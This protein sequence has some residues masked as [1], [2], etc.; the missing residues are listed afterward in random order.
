M[1][2]PN[3]RKP[4]IR[5][6]KLK[7]IIA[8]CLF[9]FLYAGWCVLTIGK[10]R[11]FRKHPQRSEAVGF[12]GG[13]LPHKILARALMFKRGTREYNQD[14][15]LW[16]NESKQ[17]SDWPW[18][19]WML[20]KRVA[21]AAPEDRAVLLQRYPLTP[22][23]DLIPFIT[24]ALNQGHYPLLPLLSRTNSEDAFRIY[25]E[26]ID[27]RIVRP[28]NLK[29]FV[30]ASGAL[31]QSKTYSFP[32]LINTY[33]PQLN[34]AQRDRTIAKIA[35]HLKDEPDTA[36]ELF[37]W[38]KSSLSNGTLKMN[39]PTVALI[40]RFLSI[41]SL[42]GATLDIIA[43]NAN[44]I[45][46]S[47]VNLL[48]RYVEKADRSVLAGEILERFKD[49][50]TPALLELIH[51]V[52]HEDIVK[53]EELVKPFLTGNDSE[54]RKGVVVVLVRHGSVV[55]KGMID[56]TFSGSVPRKTLYLHSVDYQNG[57]AATELY[58]QLSTHDYNETGKTWPPTYFRGGPSPDEVRQWK[59]FLI[60]YPWFPGT[61]DAYYRLAFSQLAQG[62][63]QGCLLTVKDYLRRDY[64]P[65]NDVKP[66][67]M[68]IL[69]N[70]AFASD[71]TDNEL[72]FLP[73]MRVLVS[74]PLASKITGPTEGLDSYIASID[75]FLSNPQYIRF[76]NTD[77]R[78]LK[79][80]RE[81]AELVQ[82]QPPDSV[83][84]VLAARFGA[85][86]PYRS[87]DRDDQSQTEAEE[88]ADEEADYITNVCDSHDEP[89][90][91][92]HVYPATTLQS[93]LYGMFNNFPTPPP[94]AM[95]TRV[96]ADPGETAVRQ[97]AILLDERLSG[98]SIEA[99][100]NRSLD[101]TLVLALLHSGPEFSKWE[102]DFKRTMTFL[103]AL[104]N[105][106]IPSVVADKQVRLLRERQ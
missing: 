92:E 64:W 27:G 94:T 46:T 86:E 28:R 33:W 93:V 42:R 23:T 97:T 41:P 59:Q 14:L 31:V 18:N 8:L 49:K 52:A 68:H 63:Y 5:S 44:A 17:I 16:A 104:D 55:G 95:I 11:S 71:L 89:K 25:R 83:C 45:G 47:Q 10:I 103:A 77:E 7:I 29:L 32:Q 38:T 96:T 19:R 82:T 69:R 62:D 12:F 106:D 6:R 87:I 2:S 73:Y 67:M 15:M 3:G 100:R 60:S 13:D 48:F 98:A 65:D 43:Q 75:W 79:M 66:Y 102:R 90:E 34:A 37:N 91:D 72:P 24:E 85:D 21:E 51:Y 30:A 78:T 9:I 35:A 20:E 80:M 1:D 40:G 84:H 50:N 61:D 81:G 4:F 57:S 70:L 88:Y 22:T 74:N 76:L 105:R 54:L 36:N 39:C 58:R 99:V 56:Q 26:W 53:A 101:E